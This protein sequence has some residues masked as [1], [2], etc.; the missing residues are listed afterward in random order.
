[1]FSVKQET[2]AP[3]YCLVATLAADVPSECAAVVLELKKRPSPRSPSFTTAEA[4]TKTL[5]GLM[6]GGRES[7]R[8]V[9]FRL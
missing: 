1:M 9:K 3:N 5:A 7:V 6:S 4:V 8:W 2:T